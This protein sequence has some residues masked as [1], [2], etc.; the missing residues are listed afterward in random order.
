MLK[1]GANKGVSGENTIIRIVDNVEVILG[2]VSIV[3][4]HGMM[5][6]MTPKIAEAVSGSCAKKSFTSFT[7]EY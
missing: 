2:P 3:L 1:A 6:E 7:R 4:P 5:G